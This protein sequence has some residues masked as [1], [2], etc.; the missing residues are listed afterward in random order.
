MNNIR[1]GEK[2]T[3]QIMLSG[4]PATETLLK[5]TFGPW[6]ND[7]SKIEEIS[8]NTGTSHVRVITITSIITTDE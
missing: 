5:S 6:V 3:R 8:R 2:S 4:K 1:T 7:N